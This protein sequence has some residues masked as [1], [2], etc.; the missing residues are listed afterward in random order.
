MFNNIGKKIKTLAAVTAWIGII[1]S[2]I[3]GLSMIATGASQLD[4]DETVGLTLI[5]SGL[6]IA[7]VGSL[8]SWIGAFVLYAYGEITDCVKEIAGRDKRTVQTAPV[9]T[10]VDPLEDLYK[11]GLI[12]EEEYQRKLAERN[13][14]ATV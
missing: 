6:G 8:L 7:V 11:K 3:A 13:G 2:I 14:G 5:F 12:T 10:A 4:W 9:Q 1:A